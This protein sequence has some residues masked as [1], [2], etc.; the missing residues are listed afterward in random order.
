MLL[1]H[2]GDSVV[3]STQH[4]FPLEIQLEVTQID[5]WKSGN[6]PNIVMMQPSMS[7]VWE[8]IKTVQTHSFPERIWTILYCCVMT[9][10]TQLVVQALPPW[11]YL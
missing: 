8:S 5:F 10:I 2:T 9:P 3:M 4:N 11:C 1:T 7:N 6:D